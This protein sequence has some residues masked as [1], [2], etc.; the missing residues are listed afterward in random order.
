MDRVLG[1]LKRTGY[2][3]LGVFGSTFVG[4]ILDDFVPGG[5]VGVAAGQYAAGSGAAYFVNRRMNASDTRGLQFNMGEAVQHASRGVG[6]A[7]F[8]EAA[9]LV[10]SDSP[11]T[12]ATA[13]TVEVRSSGAN[14]QTG[15]HANQQE[16]EISVELG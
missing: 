9:D 5:D 2:V 8:A 4:N 11:Q 10:R 15:E 1:E 7:G 16:G 6:A 14:A 12:G 3:G 13:N